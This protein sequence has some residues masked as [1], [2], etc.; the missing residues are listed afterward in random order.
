MFFFILVVSLPDW[1]SE[2]FI[3]VYSTLDV[4]PETVGKEVRKT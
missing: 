1:V 4:V 2:L 3:I